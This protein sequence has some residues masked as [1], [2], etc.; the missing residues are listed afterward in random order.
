MFHAE[1]AQIHFGKGGGQ[2]AVLRKDRALVLLLTACVLAAADSGK[3]MSEPSQQDTFSKWVDGSAYEAASE[4]PEDSLTS[5]PFVA[6]VRTRDYGVEVD[7]TGSLSSNSGSYYYLTYDAHIRSPG[8]ELLA[9]QTNTLYKPSITGYLVGFDSSPEDGDYTC[10]FAWE[11]DG[12][13]L[14]T[15]QAS[16]PIVVRYPSSL[17]VVSDTY[18]KKLFQD[19]DRQRIYQTLDED[20]SV[21][22]VGDM[23][24]T[25][26]YTPFS[27]NG[28]NIT[29]LATASTDT[30]GQGRFLDHYRASSIPMCSIDP[31][32]T[33]KTTQTI[34]VENFAV[35]TYQVTYGCSS[36]SIQ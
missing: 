15:T 16:M 31:D 25:E 19:Y 36:V 3:A 18:I 34:K 17:S 20:G 8:G 13:S 28:C 5:G 26:S 14:G 29:T 30:N 7:C 10:D 9:F 6:D 12:T 33:S 32:C 22:Q 11:V 24:V 2:M 1:S 21:L 23:H 35:A 27:P 4:M